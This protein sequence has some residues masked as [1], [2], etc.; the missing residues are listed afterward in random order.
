V[1]FLAGIGLVLATVASPLAAPA[2]EFPVLTPAW[3][4]SLAAAPAPAPTEVPFVLL[5]LPDGGVLVRNGDGVAPIDGRGATRW[6]MPVVTD[7]I[8][9]GTMVVFR[10][11]NVVFAARSRDAGVLWKHPCANPPYAVAAGDRLVTM[12]AGVSTVLSAR[13]G[14][15]IARS[16][17]K[18]ATGPPS[19]RGARPL[20]DG[21]VLVTN[22]FDGAWMG[23]SYYVVDAHTGA[24]L[25]SQTDF[26]VVAVTPATIAITPYPSMLPWGPPGYVETRRL[27][28]GKLVAFITYAIPQSADSGRG[29]LALS[30]VAAYVTRMDGA[31]F[32]FRRAETGA[33]QPVLPGISVSAEVLGGAAFIFGRERMGPGVVYLDRPSSGGAFATKPLGRYTGDMSVRAVNVSYSTAEA[34]AHVGDR[35]AIND[36]G[37]VRLYDEFGSVEMAVKTSCPHP[38]VT[39]TRSVL[40]AVCAPLRSPVTLSGFTRP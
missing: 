13:D 27:S 33:P 12:C 3:T 6:S 18:L 24:F 32:R 11:S 30:R 34:A 19:I 2:N 26:D 17:A 7:A 4:R 21:Y 20:N 22:F 25:W 10:R 40:F 36:R 5:L 37:I 1:R 9:D 23:E 14:H 39:A 28:D 15:L 29:R 38:Y 31:L 8:V 35:L 16:V